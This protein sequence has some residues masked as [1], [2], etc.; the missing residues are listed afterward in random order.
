MATPRQ[1]I[2]RYLLEKL[3]TITIENGYVINVETVT[4]KP[5][6]MRDRNI[7]DLPSIDIQLNKDVEDRPETLGGQNGNLL[8][9]TWTMKLY[10]MLADP[11]E[12]T[13]EDAGEVFLNSVIKCL[14]KNRGQMNISGGVN[15]R[16][17]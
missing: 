11:G 16:D 3:A 10:L 5:G 6:L 17:I 15:L 2:R 4:L 1:V 12:D 9:R 7:S 13:I 14:N 8:Q